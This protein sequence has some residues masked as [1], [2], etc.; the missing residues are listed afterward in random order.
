M[1]LS[2]D[3]IIFTLSYPDLDKNLDVAKMASICS[4]TVFIDQTNA[5]SSVSCGTAATC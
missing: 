2:T 4:K 5:G 3:K 1:R